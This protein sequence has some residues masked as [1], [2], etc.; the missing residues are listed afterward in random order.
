MAL[1]PTGEGLKR[2]CVP[3]ANGGFC[4]TSAPTVFVSTYLLWYRIS[5]GEG[6]RGGTPSALVAS[7][8]CPDER[9]QK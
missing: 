8:G 1:V 9:G 2:R 7:G 5:G 4:R 3:P 6:P